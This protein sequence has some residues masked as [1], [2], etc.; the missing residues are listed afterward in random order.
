MVYAEDNGLFQGDHARVLRRIKTM[1]WNLTLQDW[2][3]DRRR[4]GMEKGG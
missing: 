4:R 3:L 1:K 2:L